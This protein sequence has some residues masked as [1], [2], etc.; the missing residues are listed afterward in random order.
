MINKKLTIF[1]FTIISF[2]V[3][4]I[5]SI[6]IVFVTSQDGYSTL[7]FP[8]NYITLSIFVSKFN[9]SESYELAFNF[10]YYTIVFTVYGFILGVLNKYS[11]WIKYFS[12]LFITTVI[13][14]VFQENSIIKT[15]S[16]VLNNQ[17]VNSASVIKSVPEKI[18]KYFG[19]EAYGDLNS[20]GNEDV[21]FIIKRKDEIRGDLYYLSA[22]IKV[23]D[24]YEGL[25]LVFLGDKEIP[26]Q[27]IIEDGIIGV[28]LN[29]TTFYAQ[30]IDN[31]IKEL[32]L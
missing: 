18:K 9:F 6:V 22:S 5:L 27:I 12:V 24:G 20:D 2:F 29:K 11:N 31:E 14:L 19:L 28:E 3:A 15:A 4:V 8:L 17:Y 32:K 25:N 16:V 30:I 1:E 7:S 13:F 21:A 26:S 23:D 10:L